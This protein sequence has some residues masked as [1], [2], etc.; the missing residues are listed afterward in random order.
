MNLPVAKIIENVKAANRSNFPVEALVLPVATKSDLA[1]TKAIQRELEKEI[2]AFIFDPV[3]DSVPA[4]FEDFSPSKRSGTFIQ[5]RFNP[6]N[7]EIVPGWIALCKNLGI[8]LVVDSTAASRSAFLPELKNFPQEK[9]I[10]TTSRKTPGVHTVGGYRQLAQALAKAEI[11]SPIWIRCSMKSTILPIP[12]IHD[13]AGTTNESVP[14]EDAILE[15]A[16]LAGPLL[17]DGIGDAISVETVPE[18]SKNVEIAYAILQAARARQTKA[19]FVAC[20]SC[21]RTLYDIQSTLREIKEKTSHLDGVTI[22]VMGCIVNGPG[23]MADADF[24]YVGGAPGKINLYVKRECVETGIP[25]EQAVE[26][27]IALIKAHGKWK[28]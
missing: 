8:G 3:K 28:D 21:G 22:G 1:A 23:E 27:L 17:C 16:L 20:P 18:L 12:K 9:L 25:Q 11:R 24:G 15:A 10:F 5:R 6:A 14:D 2:S 7:A 19:E 26:R 13:S 4:L